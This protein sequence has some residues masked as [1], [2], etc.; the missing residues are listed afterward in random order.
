[1]SARSP[2]TRGRRSL[3]SRPRPP[4][5]SAPCGTRPGRCAAGGGEPEGRRPSSLRPWPVRRAPDPLGWTSYPARPGLQQSPGLRAALG[6]ERSPERPRTDARGARLPGG[7][8]EGRR[9]RPTIRGAK[10]TEHVPL[11]KAPRPT[12]DARAVEILLFARA[13]LPDEGAKIAG[14]G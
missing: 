12:L 11:D 3:G 6:Q 1:R 7:K 10:I 4:R 14:W 5:W 2:G 8:G 9:P 13:K